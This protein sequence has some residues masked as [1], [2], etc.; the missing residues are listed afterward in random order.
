[1]KITIARVLAVLIALLT[2]MSSLFNILD[3]WS[4]IETAQLLPQS[5][6]GWSNF[7]V[8]MGA[9]FLSAGLFA[10]YAAW[11]AERMAFIPVI[12]FFG[13]VLFAR[14]VGFATEG[15]DPGAFQFTALAAVVLAV[16]CVGFRL[17]SE[18]QSKQ[19]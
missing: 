11:K 9:P 7:R 19:E 6:G 10:V 14:F 12:V 4:Q 8:G 18:P 17:M 5:D 16:A 13:C 15:F 2:I 1:M 3:P